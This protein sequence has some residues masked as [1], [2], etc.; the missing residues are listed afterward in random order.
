MMLTDQPSSRS[1]RPAHQ[2]VQFLRRAPVEQALAVGRVAHEHAAAAR[3]T[4]RLP[5]AARST[6]PSRPPFA[7]AAGTASMQRSVRIAAEDLEPRGADA[8]ARLLACKA[9]DGAFPQTASAPPRTRASGRARGSRRSWA[10]S[11]GIVPEPHMGVD[12]RQLRAVA[13]KRHHR[14]AQRFRQRRGDVVGA[15]AAPGKAPRRSSRAQGSPRRAAA[16][17]RR[18]PPRRSPAPRPY[19]RRP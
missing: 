7:R 3:V 4:E 13:R 6:P 19:G 8:V 16:P 17:P 10:A 14:R 2:A 15:V 1:N 5:R 12:E 18:S 11:M 9:P